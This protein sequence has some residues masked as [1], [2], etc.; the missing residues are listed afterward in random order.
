MK[1]I[2][3]NNPIH[4][5]TLG[6]IFL[7]IAIVIDILFL[8]D[9][10]VDYTF[11]VKGEFSGYPIPAL[12]IFPLT[13]YWLYLILKKFN[14][15]SPEVVSF[16]ITLFVVM[17]VFCRKYDEYV[18]SRYESLMTNKNIVSGVVYKK[19]IPNS[20]GADFRWVKVGY[21]DNL[22]FLLKVSIM[23]YNEISI[24]D[25]ILILASREY[26]RV[27]KVL[28]WH[29]TDEEIKRYKE[30]RKFKSY[31]NGNIYEEE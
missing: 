17:T 22:R 15:S 16:L 8:L 14:S 1:M 10:H 12:V 31:S 21:G 24:G 6:L 28:K 23:D 2:D 26:P 18:E 30:P 13:Y 20:R 9:R 19:I 27:M 25:N 3:K 11:I 4:F 5:K 29:P 7:S